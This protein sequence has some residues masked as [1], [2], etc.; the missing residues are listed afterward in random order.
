M[1]FLGIFN[2][3]IRDFEKEGNIQQSEPPLGACYW[4]DEEQLARVRAFEKENNAVVYHVIHNWTNFGELENYLFVSDYP[5]EWE[6][7]MEDLK[8]GMVLSYVYNVDGG[9]ADMGS[10]GIKLTPA[11]GLQRIW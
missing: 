10:I 9:F 1:K 8:K 4:L 5:E 6:Q 3:I 7:E 11:G 2:Q